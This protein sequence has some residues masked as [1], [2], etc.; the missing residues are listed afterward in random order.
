MGF[1]ILANH[2]I[3]NVLKLNWIFWANIKELREVNL[4]LYAI[5]RKFENIQITSL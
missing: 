4:A 2:T 1:Q 3:G 5:D